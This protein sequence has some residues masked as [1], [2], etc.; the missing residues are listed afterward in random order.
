[1]SGSDTAAVE[2][3]ALLPRAREIGADVIVIACFDERRPKMPLIAAPAR[4][5]T[6][7]SQR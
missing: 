1:M 7:I 6:G 4:G 5:R 3:M 2:L